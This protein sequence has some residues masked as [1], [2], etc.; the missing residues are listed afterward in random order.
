V[1]PSQAQ[2]F[3]AFWKSPDDLATIPQA[4]LKKEANVIK[5][6]YG[7]HISMAEWRNG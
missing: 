5:V 1:T 3:L 6:V 4:T 7:I 2:I